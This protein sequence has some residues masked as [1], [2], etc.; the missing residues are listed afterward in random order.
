M[1]TLEEICE[2]PRSMLDVLE[3][4]TLE[5]YDENRLR[6]LDGDLDLLEGSSKTLKELYADY[7]ET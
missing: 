4:R 1:G 7:P 5:A 3:G 6:I 2:E